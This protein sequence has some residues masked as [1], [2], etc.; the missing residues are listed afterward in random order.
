MIQLITI[1]SNVLGVSHS[2]VFTLIQ[3]V[4]PFT[5]LLS[6]HLV[7]SLSD[8]STRKKLAEVSRDE[9]VPALITTS[10]DGSQFRVAARTIKHSNENKF[11]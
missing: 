6:N 8:L 7:D 2:R 10:V 9:T 4:L 5:R 1:Y 3:W 11:K